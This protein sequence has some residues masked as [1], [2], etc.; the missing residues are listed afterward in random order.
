MKTF[1]WRIPVGLAMVVLGLLAFLQSFHLITLNGSPWT[2]GFAVLFALVGGV[3]MYALI[4]DHT[5]WWAV[6]PGLPLIGLAVLMLLSLIPGCSGTFGAF[7]FMASIAASF[8]S[9]YIMKR[10]F[11]WAIIP[12][13]TLTSV[14]LVILLSENGN[15]G[16]AVLFLGMAATFAVL[17]L[18]P[19]NGRK[20]TWPWIPAA[21]LAVLGG[22][23]AM[24]EGGVPAIVWAILIILAG[25]FLVARPFIQ[26][27]V[28]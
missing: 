5:N 18:I 13:G 19:V 20:M 4:T 9:I 27:N 10:D 28:R 7:I 12:A 2:F 6:I 15:L 23:V 25:L 14:A 3:F 11:W 8:W 24:S 1:N 17:G 16:G 22:I 26:K 21:S